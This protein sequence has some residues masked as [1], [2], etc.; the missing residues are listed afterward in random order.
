M[1]IVNY[2]SIDPI[3]SEFLEK[4]KSLLKKNQ[5]NTFFKDVLH[6]DLPYKSSND[7]IL[8]KDIP[9]EN[10]SIENPSTIKNSFSSKENSD[11]SSNTD[12][13]ASNTNNLSKKLTD[14]GEAKTYVNLSLEPINDIDT[15]PN[16]N[17]NSY[18]SDNIFSINNKNPELII[19]HSKNKNPLINIITR[20]S[21]RPNYF[22]ECYYSVICQSYSNIRHIIGFDNYKS[23]D[24]IL[25]NKPNENNIFYTPITEKRINTAHMP[26]NLY[27]NVLM[28]KVVDGWIMF[29]DDDDILSTI[30]SI[31][32]IVSYI[33]NNDQLLIWKVKKLGQTIPNKSF[34]KKPTNGD[35]TSNS[36]MFHSKYISMAVWDNKSAG[37]F[38]V[39]NKLFNHP[40]IKT[41]WIDKILA[42][43]N[44]LDGMGRGKQ[45]DKRIEKPIIENIYKINISY[46]L[47]RNKNNIDWIHEIF[48][49]VYLLNLDR[50]KD[51]YQKMKSIFNYFDIK[52]FSR[53]SA[54]DGSNPIYKNQYLQYQLSDKNKGIGKNIPSSGSWAILLSMKTLILEA[55]HFKYQNILV[56][57]DDLILIKDFKRKFITMFNHISHLEWK[58]LYLGVSNHYWNKFKNKIKNNSIVYHPNG[59]CDGAFAVAINHSIFQ[60]LLIEIDKM[61][62]PFDSGPLKTIQHRYKDKCFVFYPNLVIADVT[63]SDCRPGRN[64]NTYSNK[65]G[66]DLSL[67]LTNIPIKKTNT[68][69]SLV[70]VIIT[71]FNSSKYIY[72]SVSSIIN[73]TYSNI[74]IIIVD[75]NSSDDTLSIINNMKLLDNRIK[76]LKNDINYGTYI[77]K[78]IGILH[79]IGDYICFHDSDDFSISNRIQKQVDFMSKNNNYAGCNCCFFSR[80]KNKKNELSPAEITLFIKKTVYHKIGFFDSVRVGA[81]TEFRRRLQLAGLK[82]Y[83]INEYLY[84]CLDRFMEC[85]NTG[86][87]TSLT[88]SKTLGVNS[89]IRTAYRNSFQEYHQ[90][91]NKNTIYMPFPLIRRL[92]H[93]KY[94]NAADKQILESRLSS[95]MIEYLSNISLDC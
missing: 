64:Q 95:K 27:L 52:N 89:N 54:V 1:D 16:S 65:F 42:K 61:A 50:R 53:F 71:C 37:D 32:T 51:R 55:I 39:S 23:L 15:I 60:E 21:K 94:D 69:N 44:N 10:N 12:K 63:N 57:Q 49:K 72:S 59:F 81:D 25:S 76:I 47:F 26:Y 78:N 87:Y 2:M 80:S 68:V 62:L 86:K 83:T 13:M 79:S 7:T 34:N 18:P 19:R 22:L 85:N 28:N 75:D 93:I 3:F 33:K 66:W 82:I 67:Y 70:S 31:D 9:N 36:F 8:N 20:T 41:V 58:L 45:I 77:S 84:S 92:F 5:L 17:N 29:L 35:I 91:I 56:F 11:I 88:T 40:N 74:E 90:T 38:R 30:N 24:Y 43:V 48:D 6:N 46:S 14:N 73:Q 4:K